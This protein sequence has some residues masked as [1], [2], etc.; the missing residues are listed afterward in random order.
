[1]DVHL[2][3][4]FERYRDESPARDDRGNEKRRGSAGKSR[5]GGDEDWDVEAAVEKRMVQVMFT[6]PKTRLRVVNDME[7]ASLM[8]GDAESV[9]DGK[10]EGGR[11]PSGGRA[12]EEEHGDKTKGNEKRDAQD[13]EKR[14]DDGADEAAMPEMEE[15]GIWRIE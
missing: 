5:D 1:M 6:V 9:K 14:R 8:S 3:G 11:T 4:G 13:K 15:K 10:E 12:G 2:R 7:R